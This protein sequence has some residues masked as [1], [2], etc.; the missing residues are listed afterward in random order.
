MEMTLISPSWLIPKPDTVVSIPGSCSHVAKNK[1]ATLCDIVFR[2]HI[3]STYYTRQP[4][5]SFLMDQGS[6]KSEANKITFSP[7]V[8][9]DSQ[10]SSIPEIS[11]PKDFILRVSELPFTAVK[12]GHDALCWSRYP[13]L[14]ITPT[15]WNSGGLKNMDVIRLCWFRCQ[16]DRVGD[17]SFLAGESLHGLLGYSVEVNIFQ[18]P[19]LNVKSF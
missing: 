13:P 14:F 9:I 2:I 15:V 18:W 4:Q 10:A 16:W 1:T 7:K 19:A 11:K 3:L 6:R 8:Q 5:D 17:R 12:A